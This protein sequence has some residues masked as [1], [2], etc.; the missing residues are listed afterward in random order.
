MHKCLNITFF[1]CLASLGAVCIAEPVFANGDHVRN[2]GWV[3]VEDSAVHGRFE[4]SAKD[5]PESDWRTHHKAFFVDK[6]QLRSW[7]TAQDEIEY[8]AKLLFAAQAK[9]NTERA[10]VKEVKPRA[11]AKPN[12]KTRIKK[13]RSISL[14][15]VRVVC[16]PGSDGRDSSDWRNHLLCWDLLKKE[17]TK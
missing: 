11:E 15:P 12:I 10:L 2:E 5:G 4:T 13:P 7:A 14:R 9:T 6:P 16:V 17:I 8:K 1:A 3:Q